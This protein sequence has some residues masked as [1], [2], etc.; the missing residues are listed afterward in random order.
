[1]IY[2]GRDKMLPDVKVLLVRT[3][4]EVIAEFPSKQRNKAFT[5]QVF[6]DFIDKNEEF[7]DMVTRT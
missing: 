1:M 2:A 4:A 3:I 6:I 7:L 5:D